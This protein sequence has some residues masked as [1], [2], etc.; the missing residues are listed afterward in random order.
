MPF[1]KG[2]KLAVGAGGGRQGYEY[3]QA[4]LNEMKKQ[5]SVFMFLNEKIMAGEATKKQKEDYAVVAKTMNKILDKLHANKVMLQGDK[6]NPLEFSV[7][8]E[9]QINELFNRRTK[10][11][12]AGGE[13]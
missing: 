11:N 8:T 2:N 13:V 10:K 9:E 6:D 5:M 4:Q 1:E 3:E 12:S 7:L